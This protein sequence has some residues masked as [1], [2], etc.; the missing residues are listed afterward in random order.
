MMGSDLYINIKISVN[1][2]CCDYGPN[3]VCCGSYCCPEGS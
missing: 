3:S 2:G 1:V